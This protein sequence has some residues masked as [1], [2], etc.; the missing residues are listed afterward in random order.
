MTTTAAL[1]TVATV[2]ATGVGGTLMTTAAALMSCRTIGIHLTVQPVLSYEEATHG[3]LMTYSPAE[4]PI[5]KRLKW[6]TKG[7]TKHFAS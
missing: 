2:T 7:S 4:I 1:M 5:I 3:G 6:H